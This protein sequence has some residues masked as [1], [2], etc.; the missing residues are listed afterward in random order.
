MKM[1][2]LLF[3]LTLSW[4]LPLSAQYAWPVATAPALSANFGELRSNHYHMGLDARTEQREN[5]RVL[6]A[7]AGYV[8]RIKIE[9]WGFGR[10]IYI[11][12]PNGVTS[13]YAHLNDFYPELE[14]WVKQQQ[15]K[16]E[17]WELDVIVPKDLFPVRKAQFIAYS[18]NTGGSMGPH[19]HFELRDTRTEVVLN[20]LKHGFSIP[21]NIAPDII[22]LALFDRCISTYEQSPKMIPLRRSGT[23]YTAT[24]PE[25]VVNTDKI[26]FAITSYD[27]YTGS[28]NQNGIYSATL[29]ED[30]VMI[31]SFRLDS[32]SYDD[33]R[34]LNAH[35]DYK[36]KL[37]GGPY[38]QHLTKLPGD[39]QS[40]YKMREDGIIY[41]DNSPRNIRIVVSD[42]EGNT[43]TI[44]LKVRAS[45]NLKS[46]PSPT[47]ARMFH[48][49]FIN[50]FENDEV[51]FHLS[52][53]SLYDSF[54]F[55]YNKTTSTDGFHTYQLHKAI[56][57]V[58]DYFPVSIK[59]TLSAEDSSK[60]IMKRWY[61]SRKDFKKASQ[62]NGWY[63]ARFRELGNFQLIVDKTPPVISA[64]SKNSSRIY[65]TI[66]DNTEELQNFR[67]ELNGKWIRFS[68]DKGRAFI[69]KFD[70]NCPQGANTLKIYVEDLA[71]NASEKT[72]NFTR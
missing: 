57:P 36:T 53:R 25:V 24:V 40:I 46:P 31:S 50:V 62:V 13:L 47:Y 68:N 37:S 67:A 27:R 72:F 60:V 14:N 11:D 30:D 34:Y 51:R 48:P 52:E 26:S 21:D 41:L 42:P 15:Y 5:L 2:Y 6:A 44:R 28:T 18:G 22:R 63:T 35:I 69:Y 32:I 45:E 7:E 19:L 58:H 39:K 38:L 1:R 61:G 4:T 65:F 71:G 59:A 16:N 70:E 10:A 33:T 64:I 56:V 17:Q 8:S 54:R 43:S 66:T 12:H 55:T 23:S 3:V 20:P 9:P 29:Y 49:G